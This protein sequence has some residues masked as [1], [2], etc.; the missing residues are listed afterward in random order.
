MDLQ[1]LHPDQ[2]TGHDENILKPNKDSLMGRLSIVSFAMNPFP[3]T[4]KIQEHDY[5]SQHFRSCL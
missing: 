2:F 3:H 5:G 1:I 4:Y